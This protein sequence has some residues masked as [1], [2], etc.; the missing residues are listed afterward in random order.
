MILDYACLVGRYRAA[1]KSGPIDKARAEWRARREERR[2][3]QRAASGSIST[4]TVTG[5]PSKTRGN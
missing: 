3:K 1:T 5:T 2:A 4:M